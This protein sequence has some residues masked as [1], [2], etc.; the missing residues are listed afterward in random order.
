MDNNDREQIILY[1]E[2]S[3]SIIQ[4]LTETNKILVAKNKELFIK[5]IK[6][7]VKIKRM[8]EHVERSNQKHDDEFEIIQI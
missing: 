4:R 5:N 1:L 7:Q 8:I 3:Y 6:L 2:K